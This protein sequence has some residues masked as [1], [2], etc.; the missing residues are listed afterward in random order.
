MV[1]PVYEACFENGVALFRCCHCERKFNRALKASVH[2]YYN[3]PHLRVQAAKSEPIDPR[4]SSKYLYGLLT[5]KKIEAFRKPIKTVK[6]V[7]AKPKPSLVKKSPI[8]TVFKSEMLQCFFNKQGK[9]VYKKT[10]NPNTAAETA[11]SRP[12][13]V[14]LV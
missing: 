2:V 4:E 11:A 14:Q 12:S 7:S 9:L 10:S 3:H 8:K 5:P 1:K 6:R 13:P